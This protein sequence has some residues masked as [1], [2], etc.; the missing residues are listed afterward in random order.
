MFGHLAVSVHAVK[1]YASEST[2]GCWSVEGWRSQTNECMRVRHVIF[3]TMPDETVSGVWNPETLPCRRIID[4]K[5]SNG[6][7]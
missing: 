7:M 4:G 1:K 6:K 5:I 3:L 2:N